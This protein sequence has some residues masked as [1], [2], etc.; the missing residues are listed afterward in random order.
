MKS[1]FDKD[2]PTL[3]ACELTTKL[4]CPEI[5]WKYFVWISD[6][7]RILAG[8]IERVYETIRNDVTGKFNSDKYRL[9]AGDHISNEYEK[10]YSHLIPKL[11]E[12]AKEDNFYTKLSS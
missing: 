6:N 3:M 9:V 5:M 1:I 7:N 10:D 4:D 11:I 12:L 2:S 8:F